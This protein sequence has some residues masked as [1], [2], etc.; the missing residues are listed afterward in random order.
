MAMDG[1]ILC[2]FFE[3]SEGFRAKE[4]RRK[5]APSRSK[6]MARVLRGSQSLPDK[7][8]LNDHCRQSN[9]EEEKISHKGKTGVIMI[10]LK[11]ISSVAP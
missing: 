9:E 4:M 3:T 1:D 7:P 11:L 10:C 8:V 5:I 6:E 2:S